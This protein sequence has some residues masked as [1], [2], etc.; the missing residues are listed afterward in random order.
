VNVSAGDLN[1]APGFF[2]GGGAR[3]LL[4]PGSLGLG[5]RLG[6]E[7]YKAWGSNTF[8]ACA[9]GTSGGCLAGGSYRWALRQQVFHVGLALSYRFLPPDSVIVPYV[10][11]TPQLY[12]MRSTITAFD[13]QTTQ[14]D[15][16]PGIN[17]AVGA[18]VDLGPGGV[19]TEIGGQYAPLD[20][21]DP[22]TDL[23]LTGD[24]DLGAFVWALGYRLE[25]EQL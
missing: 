12:A 7:R 4:G 15:V 2:V 20:P 13:N 8:P 3:L 24:A 23:G 9:G 5:L 6:Y 10:G 19:F 22:D 21:R 14:G 18:R 11:V 1:A 25:L 17:A 16:Q